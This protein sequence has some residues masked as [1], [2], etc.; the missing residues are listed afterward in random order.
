VEDPINEAWEED[1]FLK[2]V[3]SEIYDNGVLELDFL[4][5]RSSSDVFCYR[6][7]FSCVVMG[8]CKKLNS[9]F[10]SRMLSLT[11]SDEKEQQPRVVLFSDT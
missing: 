6:H 2:V 5:A 9:M 10:L 7:N 1:V 8:V 3:Q 11:S 4:S